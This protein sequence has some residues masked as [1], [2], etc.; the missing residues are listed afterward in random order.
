M[1]IICG[2]DNPAGEILVGNAMEWERKQLPVAT[3]CRSMAFGAGYI[4]VFGSTTDG[5]TKAQDA[6]YSADDG[7]TWEHIAM[8]VKSWR[9]AAAY[10]RGTFACLD[11]TI[12]LCYIWDNL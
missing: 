10:G 12:E 11:S 8:P 9:V 4:M 1:C 6:Y 2:L 7:E 5:F 3:N